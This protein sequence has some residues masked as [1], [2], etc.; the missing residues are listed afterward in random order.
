MAVLGDVLIGI[1]VVRLRGELWFSL[2]HV[3][4]NPVPISMAAVGV[5]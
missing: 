1:A 2:N 5:V 3:G 4:G